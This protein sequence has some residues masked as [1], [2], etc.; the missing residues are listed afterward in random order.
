MATF[1]FDDG[2]PPGTYQSPIG[3]V[4]GSDT[5]LIVDEL[6]YYDDPHQL[7]K[8]WPQ[9]TWDAIARHEIV[10][11]MNE[12]QA[13]MAMGVGRTVGSITAEYGNRTLQYQHEGRTVEVLF[14]SNEAARIEKK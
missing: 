7:Y 11:G 4:K 1:T 2:G 3:A 9:A 5:S 12:T 13:G 8:H 14:M 10:K 6:F